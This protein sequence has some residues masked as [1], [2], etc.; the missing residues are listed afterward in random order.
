MELSV[1]IPCYNEEESLAETHKR[2][3]AACDGAPVKGYEIILVNDGSRDKT[4]EIMKSLVA[5]DKSVV[6]V[7]LSR[8]HGHQLALSAG[9][10]Q[11]K[12]DYIFILDA[13]LQDPPELLTPML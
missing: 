1:V 7:D 3:K 11:A 5:Q 2:V 4:L 8:N 13:D 6:A 9:L 12:G 10:A